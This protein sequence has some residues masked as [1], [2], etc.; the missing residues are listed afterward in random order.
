MSS[1]RSEVRVPRRDSSVTTSSG[2]TQ[3]PGEDRRA[4]SNAHGPS[5]PASG[6]GGKRR[7]VKHVAPKNA[8]LYRIRP[9]APV[10]AGVATAAIAAVG[11]LSVSAAPVP[12]ATTSAAPRVS[13]PVA[14]TADKAVEPTP[15]KEA[16][17]SEPAPSDS[18]LLAG[19]SQQTISRDS[20]R[21]AL[22][23]VVN[24]DLVKEAEAMSKQRDIALNESAKQA[25][26]QAEKIELDAW[27]SPMSS[28][29]LTASFGQSS[30][31]WSTVHTGQDLA[32][33]S[34]TPI[35]SVA[36]GVVTEAGYDGSYGNKTVITLEDGTEIWYCHQTS[37]AVSVG[38]SVTGGELIGTVGS[39]G[40][41]TGPHLHLEVR[42]GGG[43][44]INPASALL[45]HGVQ[46]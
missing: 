12:A 26:A 31:L 19:R 4:D 18:S 1:H 25:E 39:T 38:D 29:R 2:S 34:G 7:A 42:P 15:A 32:A 3:H 40:N 23:D 33:P 13:A 8:P 27:V 24:E 22:A 35:R 45:D 37:I 44:P 16:A 46:L 9:S 10:L 41:V 17:A 6:K 14:A 30:Y 21:E 36:N 20:Q 11:A 5:R 28:Y 43:D